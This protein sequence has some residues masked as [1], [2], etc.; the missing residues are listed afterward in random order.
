MI[1]PTWYVAVG[2][3]WILFHFFAY[4]AVVRFA[5]PMRTEQGIFRYHASSCM[6]VFL[7]A[8]IAL[9]LRPTEEMLAAAVLVLSAQG[10]YSLTFIEFWSLTQGGYSLQ[11]LGFLAD[12]KFFPSTADPRPAE[13][14]AAKVRQRL[15]SLEGLALIRRDREGEKLTAKGRALAEALRILFLMTGGRSLNR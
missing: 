5:A 14:G 3:G 4:A 6:L 11:I 10:I 13:L 1:T 9:V 15:D 2:T 8:A 7:S 12:G